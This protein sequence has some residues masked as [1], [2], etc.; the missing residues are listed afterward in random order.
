V[1][2][3]SGETRAV[4]ERS[5][6]FHDFLFIAG[7]RYWTASL[8]PAIVGTT[9]PF[10]LRPPGFSFRWTAA[11]EFLA[12]TML[13][14]AGFSFLHA[15]FEHRL[16]VVWSEFSLLGLAGVCIVAG[17][18]LGLHL[19]SGLTL[20]DGVPR[21]IFVVYG[22][23]GL[24]AGVLYVVPPLNFYRR[25]G[26]ESVICGALGLVPV[27]GAYLVQVGDLTRTV[28][29][30]SSPVVV[31]TALWVWTDELITRA[32]DEKEG[33]RT[34]VVLF[35]PR[36]SGRLAVPALSLLFYATLFLAV[37]SSSVAPWALAVLL[38]IGL[39]PAIVAASWHEY[40]GSTRLHA[41]RSGAFVVH[42]VTGIVIA[43]S[44][45]VARG[46]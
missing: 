40:D 27:L 46:T 34:M 30:A 2:G 44:S 39:M 14:H 7:C 15:R 24:F 31:A 13:V 10:W 35:G 29:L 37:S 32:G 18:L 5:R 17:S 45:L 12:A 25:A 20:H 43:A 42:L 6:R 4:G 16:T 28:Y 3:Q 1:T 23:C 21:S 8:L 33:R 38:T 19:N 11:V 22:I 41:A 36:L 9:L 26:G